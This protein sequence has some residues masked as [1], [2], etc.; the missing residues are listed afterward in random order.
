MPL[1]RSAHSLWIRYRFDPATGRASPRLAARASQSR[2]ASGI[3][4]HLRSE[5]QG[6]VFVALYAADASLW[7]AIGAERWNLDAIEFSV[8]HHE[9]DGRCRFS[10]RCGTAARTLSYRPRVAM[11]GALLDPT[12]DELDREEDDF[13]LFVS[14]VLPDAQ[15]RAAAR[16]R[17][18]EASRDA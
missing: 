17:W 12:R 10:F 16:A 8:V 2:P 7:F 13:L 4:T 3:G 1:L 9:H 18:L 6:R 11:I 5:E 15:W 14:R